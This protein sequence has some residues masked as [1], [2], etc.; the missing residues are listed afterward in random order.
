MSSI[1]ANLRE[2]FPHNAAYIVGNVSIGVYPDITEDQ[3]KAVGV[4]SPGQVIAIEYTIILPDKLFPDWWVWGALASMNSPMY[5]CLR[6]PNRNLPSNEFAHLHQKTKDA[7]Q[8]IG[9]LSS[10]KK[11]MQ[12]IIEL[13]N[14][15]S[16]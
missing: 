4:I 1:I 9:D 6:K 13:I 3:S 8:L 10:L 11:S 14:A 15:I 7:N 5:I 2:K 16:K 12:D